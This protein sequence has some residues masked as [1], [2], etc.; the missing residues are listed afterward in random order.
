MS[1]E[2]YR[3]SSFLE[4]KRLPFEIEAYVFYLA[5]P[6]ALVN[7]MATCKA[8]RIRGKEVSTTSMTSYSCAVPPGHLIKWWIAHMLNKNSD[9]RSSGGKVLAACRQPAH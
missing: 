1:T 9:C 7:Y 5:G 4:E 6:D 3:P 2:Q 8:C